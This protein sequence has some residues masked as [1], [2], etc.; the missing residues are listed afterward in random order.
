MTRGMDDPPLDEGGKEVAVLG[1][2]DL[3][4]RTRRYRVDRRD[5]KE[6]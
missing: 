5:V 1:S 6:L 3:L 4:S 2:I